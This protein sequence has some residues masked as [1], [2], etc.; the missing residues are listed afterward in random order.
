MHKVLFAAALTA[1]M[2]AQA[3]AIRFPI[4]EPAVVS[5]DESIGVKLK[6]G[7]TFVDAAAVGRATALKFEVVQAGKLA[8]YCSE[9]EQAICIPVQLNADNFLQVQGRDYLAVAAI[10]SALSVTVTVDGDTASVSVEPGEQPA[11]ADVGYNA[12]WPQGRGFRTGDTVP[13]IPLTM[14]DGREVRFSEFL[15]RRYIL[16][17]WASW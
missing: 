10:E 15:G 5:A 13:D 3:K 14:I 12:D 8:T 17:C 2:P 1:V 6:G 9:G 11:A 7:T 16:Y 4:A